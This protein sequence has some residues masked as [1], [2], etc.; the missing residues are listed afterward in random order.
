MDYQTAAALE[1]MPSLHSH[2]PVIGEVEMFR[3]D[4]YHANP[5]S[6]R[7]LT[8]EMIGARNILRGN[9]AEDLGYIESIMPYH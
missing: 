7:K 3:T 2:M 6:N 5:R 8:L 4:A 1:L 9:P